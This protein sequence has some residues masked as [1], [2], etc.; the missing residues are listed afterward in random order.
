[1]VPRRQREQEAAARR[2]AAVRGVVAAREEGRTERER[3][4]SLFALHPVVD[5]CHRQ[6]QGSFLFIPYLILARGLLVLMH[7]LNEQC[8]RYDHFAK[9]LNDDGLKVYAMDWI[10]KLPA[11]E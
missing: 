4:F 11:N 3:D 2:A 10:V 9:K 8:G 1:M 7:D 5:S 6:D